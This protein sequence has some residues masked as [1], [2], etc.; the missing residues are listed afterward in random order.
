MRRSLRAA[1][2]LALA[3]G[4][5]ALAGC[6]QGAPKYYDVAGTVTY[7][8]KPIPKGTVSFEPDPTTGI[9]GQMGYADLVDSKFDT[10]AHGKGVLGGP[11]IIRILGFDGKAVYEAPYGTGLIPEYTLTKDLPK[12]DS[13]L[14]ID[15]PKGRR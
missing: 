1:A 7:G 14:E 3:A 10:R 9:R 8:G 12:A 6:G 2:G 13:T 4:M 15:V 5:V 11:Y